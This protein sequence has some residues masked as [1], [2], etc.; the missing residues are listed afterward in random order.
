MPKCSFHIVCKPTSASASLCLSS[1][2]GTFKQNSTLSATFS[3]FDRARSSSTRAA[4]SSFLHPP[5]RT[6][7]YEVL[8]SADTD[9]RNLLKAAICRAWSFS[10][11]NCATDKMD[12]TEFLA[13]LSL[14]SGIDRNSWTSH[15]GWTINVCSRPC[16]SFT[17]WLYVHEEL[18]NTISL[19]RPAMPYN[20]ANKR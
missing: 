6:S 17:M 1:L 5:I 4:S 19:R 15:G 16:H 3:S 8:A 7:L 11:R 9:S 13:R 18:T 20:Q 12:L 2:N 10:G 14:V